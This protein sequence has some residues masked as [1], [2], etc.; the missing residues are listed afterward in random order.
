LLNVIC[1]ASS[2][3][4][5]YTSSGER[6]SA[7]D[8][9]AGS[10]LASLALSSD[11]DVVWANDV[12]EKK[13]LVYGLNHPSQ[14][15]VLG[16]IRDVRGSDIPHANLSWAS[17]PCQD[18]SLAGKYLGLDGKRS[19]LVGEWLRVLDE[20]TDKPEVVCL[21]NVLGLITSNGGQDL[22]NVCEGLQSFG[23]QVGALLLDA[24][25]WVPQSRKRVFLVGYLSDEIP[26]SLRLDGP[27]SWSSS[28]SMEKAAAEIEGWV[29]WNLPKPDGL[30]VSLEDV[31]EMDAP[32]DDEERRQHLIELI[33]NRHMEKLMS[34]S[35]SWFTGYRRTRNHQQRLEL[36]FDGI[37]G[38]LRTSN[39]G[40]SRQIVVH[41]GKDGRIDTRLLTA[42]ETARLMGAD[43]YVLPE[44]YNAAYFAMG[45][46]VCVPVVRHLVH[47]LL[48]PL[49]KSSTSALTVDDP[50]VMAV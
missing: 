14:G 5:E 29:W 23:Y 26:Q 20:T 10:G 15:L 45:D 46:A 32:F 1:D 42:R 36:R 19:G 35:R 47:E 11:F 2:L 8:F 48:L 22:K 37:A 43:D 25:H 50:C 18:L 4:H 28:P 44:D 13:A 7:L 3:G 16:D 21:E 17:F 39:G 31:L 6:L 30:S 33:P 34:S 9:F 41:K 49:A 12:S 40:S 38:C 27:V 24:R